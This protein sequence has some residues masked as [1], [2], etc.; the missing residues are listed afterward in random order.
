MHNNLFK[1]FPAPRCTYLG[2]GVVVPKSETT[3]KRPVSRRSLL[4]R[5]FLLFFV[6]VSLSFMKRIILFPL[7]GGRFL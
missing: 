5:I 1:I 7:Q 2:V 6:V 4:L 3:G